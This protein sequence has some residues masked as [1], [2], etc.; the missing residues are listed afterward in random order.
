MIGCQIAL[1]KQPEKRWLLNY[2]R[3]FS[4]YPN[5]FWTSPL[6]EFNSLIMQNEEPVL[7][8]KAERVADPVKGCLT[9]AAEVRCDRGDVWR[10]QPALPLPAGIHAARPR[11]AYPC[12]F[13][14][15]KLQTTHK[16]IK[17]EIK[18]QSPLRVSCVWFTHK[19]KNQTRSQKKPNI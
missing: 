19:C 15:T 9:D 6:T 7:S 16:E 18:Q 12:L 8:V 2:K 13:S 3:F 4:A 14:Y 5:V 11:L 10:S 1:D 17:R